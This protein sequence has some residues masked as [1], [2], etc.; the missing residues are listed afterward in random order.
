MKV[1]E[2]MHFLKVEMELGMGEVM[3]FMCLRAEM[4]SYEPAR[5]RPPT[6]LPHPDSSISYDPIRPTRTTTNT[7]S[8]PATSTLPQSPMVNGVKFGVQLG[9]GSHININ[10]F[11]MSVIYLCSS[12]IHI[13]RQHRDDTNPKP[14]IR[15][16]PL[17]GHTRLC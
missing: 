14:N 12:E 6:Y 16:H 8:G 2:R 5:D 13:I 9:F 1:Q 10:K 4:L 17:F 15:Q 7:R 3:I 11:I